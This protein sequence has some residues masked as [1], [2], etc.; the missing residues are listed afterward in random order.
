MGITERRQREKETIRQ[1]IL[2]AALQLAIDE[3]WDSV[4]I[5]KIA[6][7]IEYSPP[8][9]YDYFE[10]K[11]AIFNE[12]ILI[13]CRKLKEKMKLDV[14]TETDTKKVLQAISLAHWDFAFE[15]KT[16]Y[17]LMFSP[18]RKMPNQKMFAI[19]MVIKELFKKMTNNYDNNQYI[20]ELIFNWMCLQ[21]GIIFSV[22]QIGLPPDL[23]KED[24]Q[25][26]F[27]RS[28]ERFFKNF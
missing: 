6:D 12:L 23:Q 8:I 19:F 9:V 11:E 10:N 24:P 27:T 22:M 14:L 5:R 17:R 26:L 20:S 13:G 1:K 3:G 7:T 16:L 21:N 4:T 25:A 2:D 28:V 18:R 15:N